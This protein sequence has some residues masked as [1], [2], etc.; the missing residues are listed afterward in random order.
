MVFAMADTVVVTGGSGG[1]GG[2]VVRRLVTDGWRVVVPDVAA[3]RSPVDGVSYVSA[4]LFS[5]DE[6]ASVVASAASDVDSPLRAVVNLVGGFSM[7]GLVHETPIEDFEA[8]L[9]LNLRP[10]YLVCAAALPALMAAGGGSIVCVS[11][12]AAVRPFAGAAGYVTG[13]AAVLALV[14]ALAVEYRD[15]GVRANA[16]LPSVI[17]TPANR[18]SMPEADFAKWVQPEQIA[19]VIAF[20][21]SAASA[22]T[23]GAHIPVYGRA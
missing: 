16:I 17:D 13:K 3:P 7:G 21:C 15:A 8:Q 20:L 9:R 14:D 1:L 23:S 2:A 6:V 5:P 18:A 10:T 12:R 19:D 11:S 22:V 4:D